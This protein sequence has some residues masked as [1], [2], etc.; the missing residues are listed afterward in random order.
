MKICNILKKGQFV[1]VAAKYFAKPQSIAIFNNVLY[2]TD[3]GI[4]GDGK[5]QHCVWKI[6]L[7]SDNNSIDNINLLAGNPDSSYLD[8]QGSKARFNSPT[9]IDIDKDGTVFIADTNN[10]CIRSITPDGTAATIAGRGTFSGYK[11][12]MNALEALFKEPY[13]LALDPQGRFI[14]VADSGNHCIRAIDRNTCKVKTIAGVPNQDGNVDGPGEVA[15][16]NVPKGLAVDSDGN[17]YVADYFNNKIRKLTIDSGQWSVETYAGSGIEGNV[18]G[19]LLES[20]FSNPIEIAIKPLIGD[21]Y[22][23]EQGDSNRIRYVTSEYVG[24][25]AG[26]GTA[27]PSSKDIAA[28]QASFNSLGGLVFDTSNNIFA[29]ERDL[30]AIIKFDRAMVSKNSIMEVVAVNGFRG[31]RDGKNNIA[32]FN[33]PSAICL[34]RDS[35]CIYIADSYNHRIRRVTNDGEVTTFAGSGNKGSID[36]D[37]SEASFNIP[38]RIAIDKQKNLYV[39]EKLGVKLR[40]IN[41]SRQVSSISLGATYICD[42]AVD[43]NDNLIIN[44]EFEDG[45]TGIKVLGKDRKVLRFYETELDTPF[46][47][48]EKGNVFISSEEG[49][50]IFYKG[51]MTFQ[52]TI[53]V[54]VRTMIAAKGFI[55]FADG[56]E[57]CKIDLINKEIKNISQCAHQSYKDGPINIATF[58]IE[59]FLLID[60]D[61]NLYVSDRFNNCI[62][63]IDNSNIVSTVAGGN[64]RWGSATN[65]E[66]NRP[67]GFMGLDNKENI[68]FIQC[69]DREMSPIYDLVISQLS[70][71]KIKEV[72]KDWAEYDN[73]GVL[74]MSVDGNIYYFFNEVLYKIDPQRQIPKQPIFSASGLIHN[75]SFDKINRIYLLV[76]TYPDFNKTKLIRLSPNGTLEESI[77]LDGNFNI[78]V[79]DVFENIYVSVANSHS[80]LKI[81]KNKEIV[82]YGN[83]IYGTKDGKVS[84]AQF[85]N[86]H[87]IAIDP[88]QNNIYVFESIERPMTHDINDYIPN[89]EIKIRLVNTDGDVS[90]MELPRFHDTGSGPLAFGNFAMNTLGDIFSYESNYQR[91]VKILSYSVKIMGVKVV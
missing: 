22:V 47:I 73:Y 12:D 34:D 45:K 48:D 67:T 61:G 91:L 79:I 39:I 75:I 21:L 2:V 58:G 89:D 66:I 26:G 74:R 30:R 57:L 5:T 35:K 8:E 43:I 36:G 86:I 38:Q 10:H 42:I 70:N 23:T 72:Y 27:M 20:K 65:I 41:S 46:A 7:S 62:R 68:Y 15:K 78:L 90:T 63:K 17:I 14:Y 76:N 40:M 33:L 9:A 28:R 69:T 32:Q 54:N 55:F 13:G 59:L 80:F 88:L 4:S 24:T 19:P 84:L 25:L 83:G 18:D 82:K 29:V 37:G 44:G 11:D 31:Y 49:I 3:G 60:D 6:V 85:R 16:F 1:P 53:K 56:K 52:E 50:K 51:E 87:S 81:T 64:G 77:D 71:G